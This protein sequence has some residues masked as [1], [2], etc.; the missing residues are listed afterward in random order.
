MKKNKKLLSILLLVILFANF[1]IPTLA[2]E[3]ETTSQTKITPLEDG[4]YIME[5]LEAEEPEF[6]PFATTKTLNATNT[7]TCVANDGST[8]WWF[9]LHATFQYN[10]QDSRCT[11]TSHT[12][13]INY[14]SWKI[15]NPLTSRSGARATGTA[16]AKETFLGMTINT[17]DILARINCSP[18]GKLSY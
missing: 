3:N 18:T 17:Y 1:S 12:S 6:A 13:Q 8:L 9:K 5:V 11:K 10:G 16:F 15:L 2:S 14:S 4:Y 7:V